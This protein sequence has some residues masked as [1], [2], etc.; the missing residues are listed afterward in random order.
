M[1]LAWRISRPLLAASLLLPLLT[2]GDL[3][4]PAGARAQDE[5]LERWTSSADGQVLAT[6][7]DPLI[8]VPVVVVEPEDYPAPLSNLP[9][10][11]FLYG[12]A[13]APPG[14][15]VVVAGLHDSSQLAFARAGWTPVMVQA[16]ADA[17]G[18]SWLRQQHIV[19]LPRACSSGAED[20]GGCVDP[21]VLEGLVGLV[22]DDPSAA[23]AT[24]FLSNIAPGR[25]TTLGVTEVPGTLVSFAGD[26]WVKTEVRSRPDGSVVAR[27]SADIGHGFGGRLSGYRA[28][29]VEVPIDDSAPLLAGGGTFGGTLVEHRSLL[30]ETKVKPN[31]PNRRVLQCP[32]S[33]HG[34][35]ISQFLI[36]GFARNATL[37]LGDDVAGGTSVVVTEIVPVDCGS[38]P[39]PSA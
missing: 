6:V 33:G 11:D 26:A 38:G 5:P 10:P 39:P 22:T 7:G 17:G 18:S 16:V 32:A 1:S 28:Q 29:M 23:E 21:R 27:G 8:D 37:Y 36:D 19:S 31:E 9:A 30:A 25:F 14:S 34:Y 12:I 3:L 13:D 35:V 2:A 4:A 20:T 24:R 15:R